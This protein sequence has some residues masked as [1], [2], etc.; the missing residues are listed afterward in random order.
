MKPNPL[1][2]FLL[3]FVCSLFGSVS[4]AQSFG[5]YASAVW[6]T[7]CNTNNFFNTSNS[8]TPAH[9]IGPAANTFE[10][11]D[12]G[13]HTQNSGTLILRG[14]E[15]KT[16]KGAAS[17]VCSARMY[18][19]VY[20]ASG[21][22]GAF[23][24]IDFPFFENCNVGL[25]QF[26]VSGGPCG[27]G[28]QKWQRVIPNGATVPFA[29]VNLTNFAPGNYVLEVYYD[30][31]GSATST[32]LCNE[33]IVLNNGGA[34]YRANFS[35]QAPALSS[36]NPT[37]CNGTEGSI[38]ISGLAPGQT[39]IINY[40][41]SGTPVGPLSL[42][43]NGS[44]Q[45]VLTGLNA[46]LYSNFTVGINGCSTNLATAI[47]L[48]NPLFT[49]TFSA[50][51]AFCAGTPPPVLPAVSNNG[52]AGTWSPATV[53][54]TAS[55]SYTFTPDAGQC[56][57]PITLNVTV[58]PNITPTFSF[59][60]SLSIC[61]GGNVP[62]LPNTSTNG[63]AGTW[64]PAVVSN[65]SNGVYTFT[66]D[67]GPCTVPVTFTVT[68]TPN[69]TP[70]FS[71]GTSLSI[72]SGAS[73]P[74]LPTTSDNGVS[75]TWSPATVSNTGSGT[76]T[77]TPTAGQCATTATFS[78]TVAPNL[79]P[80]FSFGTS[81]SI[82][83]G[84]NVPAL[85]GTST[86]GITGTWSPATVSN[87]GSGTYTFTPTA[88]QC[89]TTTTFTV[90]VAANITPTFS[91]GTSLSICS[92]GTVPAL[93]GTSTNG[94][95]G[96][97]SPAV[98]SNTGSGTYT[99][100]PDGGQCATT[101]TFSVTVA[102]NI[103]PSFS[104]G[105][106]LSICSGGTVPAL[107]GTSTNGITG[108]WSP[109]TV[110]NT[111]SGTYTFT[112]TAGQC[113][114]TT[115]FTVTVAPNITPSFSFGTSLSI[116]S[117]GTVPTLPGTSTNGITGTWS[118]ATVSN[119]GSGTY[120]FTPT[121]GQ[122]ATTTTF[123]VTVAPN[124]TPS[125]SFGTSLSICSGGTVPALPGTSTN[126]ITGTWSP[127]TVSN[128]A[129][130]TYTFTPTAG[131]CAVPTTFT[132]TVNPILTPA[133]SFG[134]SLSICSGGTVPALPTTSTNGITGTWSP[135]TVSNTGSGTYTFTPTAGQCATTTTFTVTVAPNLTP[136][137]S[138]GTTLSICSGGTVPALP[139]T[140]TNGITGTW[141]P[142]TVS[143][144]GSGTYTF[145][146]T[147]GQ[148]ATTATFTVT[149]APNL[150]PTFSFGTSLS[151]CN[152]ANVPSLPTTS[153]N[154]ITG[155]WSPATV[156]NTA[157]G[158]YTFTPTAGQCA[159]PTTFTVTVNPVLTPAFSFGTTLSICSGGT[160]P[161][162]PGTST[163]GVTG[164]WSPATVSN[165]ANGTYTFTPAA[166]QCATTTTF[167]VTVTPNVTPTFAFGTSLSVCAGGTVPGELPGT[168]NNGI[169]GSWSP[170]VVS[171]TTSGTYTFTPTAGQCATTA[172]FTVTVNPIVTPTF[173]FGTTL[174]LCSGAN[175]P[176][177]PGS[178]SNGITGS[179]SPATISNTNGGTY[180]FTP[181]AGQCANTATLTV[182][183]NPLPTVVV[184]SDTSVFDGAVVPAT[185]FTGTPAGV[186][187]SW[188]NSNPAIGLPASGTGNVPSFTAINRGN[189]PI[190]ATITVT[191]SANG[192]TGAART[193][194]ITVLPLN[195]DV[196]VPNVFS[197]NGDGK[198]DV[199]FVYGN[200]IDRLEMRIFNQWGQQVFFTNSRNQGWDGTHKGKPQPVG[201]YVYALRVFLSDGRSL[202]LKGSITLLR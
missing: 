193:Y 16:F 152:G 174:T 90:T 185:F 3:L 5:P 83:S 28:D 72:C 103:T 146:P 120:T 108:T 80:A 200:Y 184:R 52:Y 197:P 157:N 173:S 165:T 24:S 116:C 129:N 182:T 78:V 89:A 162:L 62:A 187:F 66:P 167:T 85:P 107:P 154:G 163:N 123:T 32:T 59:G 75:G 199:L 45:I 43:A 69:V 147:A 68:V 91:F 183:V 47:S 191:A 35:I 130:G 160:V 115:T 180:T 126:G 100:T 135:A 175:A 190:V 15:V 128:T 41:D 39:Y 132:V 61:S 143:N 13:I 30:V 77:F 73:V 34:N 169:N 171:N 8:R 161:T 198:N 57:H 49:P 105:T 12:F 181:A 158:T 125:F 159:V 104:F 88:G 42:V 79:T 95:T 151:V 178:S 51:P 23:A 6:I 114:T 201:V 118:P 172:T 54:N 202:N 63:I 106:S 44:G 188:T 145:T 55:G 4:M 153:T 14:G 71:F 168:S 195:K 133:F 50:I 53:S 186:T 74:S 84:G 67:P 87:T 155:T 127:A 94:I 9:L 166:G 142:A 148:C 7:D 189:D 22:P 96:T 64:S 136:S 177:L 113:A 131:Q 176:A 81:L 26:S 140:S 156:S 99:F 92:G 36:T 29:P 97:W 40:N 82:C 149:V 25:S 86:N 112:P 134:T 150:I 37:T 139:G 110:S 121:A 138:F 137:F 170:A 93:P 17:N 48:T 119:T 60:T 122:C 117:G 10:N 102:P 76:Y 144:T 164:T 20:L 38:T 21:T 11:R 19:R 101:T 109:A 124:I 65:T 1:P 192:C 33:T 27:V 196:F 58:T 194:R 141:S 56:A 2:F 98:V 18:Y 46:G 70:A 31:T 111:G 179:W